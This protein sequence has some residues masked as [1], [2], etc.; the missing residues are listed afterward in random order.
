MKLIGWVFLS[1]YLY[2]PLF[3]HEIVIQPDYWVGNR[4]LE[5]G[6]PWQVPGSIYKE[7][8][9]C[10]PDDIVLEF[11]A[12][13][14]T[15]FF[16]ARCK[17]VVTVETDPNWALAVKKRLKDANLNNVIMLCMTQQHEIEQF[18]DKMDTGNFNILSV[19]TVHGYNR[20]GFLGKFLQK[21]ISDNLRMVV[22]DNYGAPELFQYHYNKEVMNLDEWSSY[23]YDDVHW[24]GNGTKLYIRK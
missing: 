24:C 18:L 22:L 12:G 11:G 7:D 15:V 13:G 19:D 1:S 17:T 16:A 14:S 9:N 10:R 21:G 20:S 5:Y 2:S 8:E 23:V 6:V 3:S 4:C